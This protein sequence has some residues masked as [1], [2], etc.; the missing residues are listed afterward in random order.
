MI[1]ISKYDITY[2][3]SIFKSKIDNMFVMLH[4]AIMF[5]DLT[6][7]D[8]FINDEVYSRYQLKINE[9]KSNNLRQMYDE[10]NVKSTE[11]IEAEIVNDK[12]VVKVLLVSRYM[13]YILNKTSGQLISGNNISRIEKEN[14]ITVEKKLKAKELAISRECQ[15]C[16]ASLD[17]NAN[18]KCKY[19]RS[20]FNVEDYDW[21]ITEI[22]N[23]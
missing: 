12:I 20:I 16:G 4:T 19:C 3:E 6:R 22:E 5:E 2:V 11:I 10:L 13:D 17:I 15:S 1:D 23:E 9:L 7:V 14:Y 18:G 21:V 8:H